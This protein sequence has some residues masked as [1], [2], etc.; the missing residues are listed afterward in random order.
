M[1]PYDIDG[2]TAALNE[3]MARQDVLDRHQDKVDDL[4]AEL[5][6]THTADMDDMIVYLMESNHEEKVAEI[7]TA[8]LGKF[9]P[10]RSIELAN[11][12]SWF[13]NEFIP[14]ECE[15]LAEKELESE[16]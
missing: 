4:T 9:E 10:L 11:H 13:I 3:Y 14:V 12:K 8:A 6:Q 15:R 5:V 16:D 1:R 2:N 7:L